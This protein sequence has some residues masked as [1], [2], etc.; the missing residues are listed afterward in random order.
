MIGLELPSL[1]WKA[2]V[3]RSALFGLLLTG[4]LG[5]GLSMAAEADSQQQFPCTAGGRAAAGG[6]YNCWNWTAEGG[7]AQPGQF[8]TATQHCGPEALI[9]SHSVH[10][11]EA[12]LQIVNDQPI[13][14][15]SA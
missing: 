5:E 8:V 15:G 13:D 6:V 3:L 1:A 12:V 4:G 9:V 14:N 7:S 11:E 10:R 2:T